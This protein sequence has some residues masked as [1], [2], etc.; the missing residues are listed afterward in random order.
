VAKAKAD[1]EWPE[2]NDVE[3]GIRTFR[4]AGTATPARS[5]RARLSSPLAT[6]FTVAEASPMLATPSSA[7]RRG[8]PPWSASVAATA[9]HNVEW[10]AAEDSRRRP[11]SRVG[12][13]V[14]AMAG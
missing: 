8:R 7:A 1:A 5:G 6:M 12:E 4:P 10:S 14:A 2:G 3:A 13:V 11:R 9:S